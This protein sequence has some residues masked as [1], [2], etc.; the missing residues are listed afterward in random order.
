MSFKKKLLALLPA[1]RVEGPGITWITSFPKSGNTWVRQFLYAY[2]KGAPSERLNEANV[3]LPPVRKLI[4]QVG[5]Q[6]LGYVS[7]EKMREQV[8]G[9]FVWPEGWEPRVL[10]KTHEAYGKTLLMH[11]RTH[12]AVLIYRDPRDIII[13]GVNYFAKKGRP[14]EDPVNFVRQFIETGGTPAWDRMSN[15]EGH[16]ESWLKQKKFPVHVLNYEELKSDP[17]SGFSGVIEFLGFPLEENRLETA[18]EATTLEMLRQ[19]EIEHMARIGDTGTGAYFFN[20][21][22]SGQSLDEKFGVEGLDKRFDEIFMPRVRRL[23]EFLTARK[24]S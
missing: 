8:A 6:K 23:E 4:K 15:W 18:L 21:G 19:L 17:R 10:T 16:W 7:E 20:E 3:V 22:K 12:S 14:L 9:D 1:P 5:L 11:R 24:P 2:I 13:S